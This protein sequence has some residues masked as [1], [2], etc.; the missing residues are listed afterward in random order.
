MTRLIA[1]NEHGY[2]IGEDHHNAKYS[3]TEVGMVFQLRDSGMSYL[4]IAR[5]ME[6]PKSTIRDF[7]KGHKRCQFAAKHKK[8]E[9]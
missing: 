7:I 8:V 5:K 4:E 9:V 6:I 2:R 3:N 1:V